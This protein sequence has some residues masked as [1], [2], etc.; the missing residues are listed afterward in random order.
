MN[1]LITQLA[2]G[3]NTNNTAI[4]NE[5]GDTSTKSWGLEKASLLN[6]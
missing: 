2:L 3:K 6:F 1:N 5:V 4:P